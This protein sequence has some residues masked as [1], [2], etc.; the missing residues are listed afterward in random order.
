[1]FRP[2]RCPNRRCSQHSSPE[3]RFFRRKGFYQARCRAAPVPRFLCRT[4]RRT[5]SRQTFRADYRDHRPDL[6]AR[7]FAAISSGLSLRRTAR[8]VGLSL[9]CTELK[10]RKIQN[11]LRRPDLD[12]R[13]TL[14]R[15][16][17]GRSGAS[18]RRAGVRA[19]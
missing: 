14:P 8:K 18:R 17:A 2:P 6:N 3:P 4:C 13:G 10:Y 16:R 15:A 12:L 7:V 1:M 19:A 9:R 11:A 5:F